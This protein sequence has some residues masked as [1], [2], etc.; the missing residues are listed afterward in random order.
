MYGMKYFIFFKYVQMTKVMFYKSKYGDIYNMHVLIKNDK[1]LIY[2]RIT[3]Y[4]IKTYEVTVMLKQ[5]IK[6][7]ANY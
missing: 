3:R 7:L 4:L 2:L 6:L 5:R 1:I